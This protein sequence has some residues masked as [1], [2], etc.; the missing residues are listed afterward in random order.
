MKILGFELSKSKADE[1]VP[2]IYGV[3]YENGTPQKSGNYEVPTT[4]KRLTNIPTDGMKRV[5]RDHIQLMYFRDDIVYNGVNIWTRLL[6]SGKVKWK[7]AN[8]EDQAYMDMWSDNTNL[9]GIMYD[10]V[11][12]TLI[13]GIGWVELKYAPGSSGKKILVGLD[14]ISSKTMDFDRDSMGNIQYD[15]FGFPT[16][17]IQYLPMEVEPLPGREVSVVSGNTA[18]SGSKAQAIK[19]NELAFFTFESI[20]GSADGVGIVEPQYDIVREKRSISKGIANAI[21]IKGSQ[22]MDITLGNDKYRPSPTERQRIKTEIESLRAEDDIIHE[23]WCDIKVLAASD[24]SSGME[25]LLRFYVE[26]QA[27][28]MGLPVA[29]V[30]GSGGDTNRAT[31]GDQ[32]ILLYKGADAWKK[33][34]ARQFEKQ[35]VP[36][37]MDNHP[38]AEP[39]KLIWE[40]MG[41]DD[42]ESRSLRLQRYA[43]SGILTTDDGLESEVRKE[44]SLPLDFTRELPTPVGTKPGGVSNGG[45]VV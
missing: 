40:P 8:D 11:K 22:R 1:Y 7:C 10:A 44:E 35:I 21:M 33:K 29:F 16:G 20:G 41:M 37:I 15:K 25:N 9:Y 26:R 5:S 6:M 13:F 4:G 38:F 23:N 30:T 39:P 3:S 18:I 43:K 32:K 12:N 28:C 34:F 2:S 42:K 14:V 17:Y 24:V 19:I 27:S 31:L 45:I 36:H